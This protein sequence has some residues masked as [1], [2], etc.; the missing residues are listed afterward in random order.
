MRGFFSQFGVVTRVRL[1]RSKKVSRRPL[2]PLLF[3][4]VFLFTSLVKDAEWFL[5]EER[6]ERWMGLSFA[7]DGAR[8][9][10]SQ[11]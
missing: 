5:G 8:K 10:M 9:L 7:R 11:W 6:G 4:F 2:L 1:S 3:Q